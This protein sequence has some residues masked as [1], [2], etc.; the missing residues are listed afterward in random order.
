MGNPTISVIIPTVGRSQ[1]LS[2]CIES[3]LCQIML[4]TEIIVIDCSTGQRAYEVLARYQAQSETLGVSLRYIHSDVSNASL[5]KNVGISA[6]RG[7]IICFLD[8]DVLLERTYLSVVME[9]FRSHPDV[10]GVGGFILSPKSDSGP[11][12]WFKRMFL[13]NHD[14]GFGVMQRSGFPAMQLGRRDIER[15]TAT[16]L[17]MGCACYRREAIAQYGGFDE[18]LGITH[19]WEDIDLPCRLSK[20]HGLLYVPE[21]RMTHRHSP[22]GRMSLT[23]YSACYMYNHFYLFDKFVPH[24][25]FN[26]LCF[27]WSHIG[28]II[29][30]LVLGLTTANPLAALR[31]VS[32][33]NLWITRRILRGWRP[34]Y[35]V[36]AEM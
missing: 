33:G 17:L 21:A 6:S 34:T 23:R 7:D 2:D 14:H 32:R 29:Y 20:Y 22:G 4:P 5:Q 8:D 19:V 31:G 9:A 25:P 12:L 13:M 26:W 27:V 24:T 15:P 16:Q 35:D 36:V 18:E 10:V 30:M 11:K 3:I 28:S 1:P